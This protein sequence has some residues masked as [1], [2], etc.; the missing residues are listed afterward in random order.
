MSA[1]I[2]S[3]CP[4]SFFGREARGSDLL[5]F[6]GKPGLPVD[7]QA[8]RTLGPVVG[9]FREA[10]V[11]AR[12]RVKFRL[13]RAVLG[14]GDGPQLRRMRPEAAAASRM[15]SAVAVRAELDDQLAKVTK[16]V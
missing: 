8:S 13:G 6:L 11:A 7:D 4:L 1:F 15:R 10:A 12:A 9:D 16:V 3:V 14:E 5:A 2:D